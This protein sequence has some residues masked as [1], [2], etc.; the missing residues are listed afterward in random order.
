MSIIFISIRLF[1]T[2]W[3]IT[4]MNCCTTVNSEIR[5]EKDP[6]S[7]FLIKGVSMVAP[8]N[9][10]DAG[11]LAPI[12]D[13]HANSIVIMPYAFCAQDKPVIRY[14]NMGQWWGEND[15]GVKGSIKL[16]HQKNL[17]VMLKPHLWIGRGMYTGAFNLAGEKEWKLYQL[18]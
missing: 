14:N 18:L 12:I 9:K 3:I 5:N 15:E 16:A 17:T 7:G 6:L 1:L 13:I 11:A 4:V 10:I 2:A 8:V